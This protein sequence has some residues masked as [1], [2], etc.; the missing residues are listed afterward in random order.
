[1]P[2]M[3]ELAPVVSAMSCGCALISLADRCANAIWDVEKRGVRNALRKFF[4]LERRLHGAE[5]NFRHRALTGEIEVD[6]FFVFEPLLAPVGA[7]ESCG[8]GHGVCS[9][10]GILRMSFGETMGAR[11]GQIGER[12][13]DRRQLKVEGNQ[14]GVRQQSH[15]EERKDLPGKLQ[16][17]RA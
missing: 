6:G 11:N 1:M 10:A 14:H 2:D 15:R 3:P 12:R 9:C 4:P 17:Q 8:G 13:G 16:A 7:G 5:G